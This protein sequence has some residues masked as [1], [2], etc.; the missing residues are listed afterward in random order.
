C[1]ASMFAMTHCHRNIFDSRP[2][3][4][5]AIKPWLIATGP[6]AIAR[7][8]I[9]AREDNRTLPTGRR[10]ELILSS[11]FCEILR[12]VDSKTGALSRDKS[13]GVAQ[14]TPPFH[15]SVSAVLGVEPPTQRASFPISELSQPSGFPSPSKL[16]GN[17]AHSSFER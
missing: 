16:L 4:M 8:P 7:Y 2:S 9:G 13:F 14:N 15:R 6:S 12:S 11:A 5:S 10:P 17:S 1:I 3:G